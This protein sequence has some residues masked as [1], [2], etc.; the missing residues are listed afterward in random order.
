VLFFVGAIAQHWDDITLASELAPSLNIV[1]VD[2]I[3]EQ[4][5]P[6]DEGEF[7][8]WSRSV[9]ELLDACQP[10]SQVAGDPA[11]ADLKDAPAVTV[12]RR[13]LEDVSNHWTFLNSASTIS[14][15][16]RVTQDEFDAF[17]N[18]DDVWV[19]FASGGAFRRTSAATKVGIGSDS[20]HAVDF[21]EEIIQR[22]LDFESADIVSFP[23]I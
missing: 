11:I 23:Q 21:V 15:P 17:L 19:V 18:G 9:D 7:L 13:L 3:G 20:S 14:P 1:L 6:S 10:I 2:A 16:D 5:L 12:D 8:V 22:T 4:A